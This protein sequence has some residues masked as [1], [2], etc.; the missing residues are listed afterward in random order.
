ARIDNRAGRRLLPSTQTLL[1][2]IECLMERGPGGA[3]KPGA[4]GQPGAPGAGID[5]VVATVAPCGK[6]PQPPRIEPGPPRTLFL[7]LPS[8]LDGLNV[9]PTIVS[10]GGT[11][12]GEVICEADGK[13]TLQLRLPPSLDELDVTI[14]TLEC[15][16]DERP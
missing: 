5:A 2:L 3:G 13:R 16:V 9:R 8:E 4:P 12:G 10:C 6:G 11:P 14:D 7:E 1:E 15:G